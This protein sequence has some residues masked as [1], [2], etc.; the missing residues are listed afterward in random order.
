MYTIALLA[1]RA[2]PARPPW[3]STWPPISRALAARPPW[4]TSTPRPAP[5]SGATGGGAPRSWAPFPPPRLDAA[6][7]AA[8]RSGAGP[9]R[10]RYRPALRIRRAGCRPRRRPGPGPLR[11]GLFDIAALDATA[12]L[13]ALAS[14]P[15]AV[16]LNHVPPR[17]RTTDLA[18]A[19]VRDYGPRSRRPASGRVPPSRTACPWACPWR[20]RTPAA[21]RLA[22]SG[23]SERAAPFTWETEMPETDNPFRDVLSR[24]DGE[25]APPQRPSRNRGPGHRHHRRPLFPGFHRQLRLLGV[26]Q[27]RTVQSLLG[28]ALNELF[29]KHGSPPSRGSRLGPGSWVLGAHAMDDV[30][31]HHRN[32]PG[33]V[34]GRPSRFSNRHPARS[35]VSAP[36]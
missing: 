29:R 30:T 3:P 14:L 6:L 33:H 21:R 9:C 19:A 32:A 23:P 8:R 35:S 31:A 15:F 34:V 28:E 16:V 12:R 5:P 18:E 26:M 22:R 27:D 36:S 7:A 13:C 10:D 4:S 25:T 2:A 24:P 1:R 11:P 20:R 17:G